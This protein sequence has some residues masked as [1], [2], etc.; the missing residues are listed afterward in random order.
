MRKRI[1]QD[2]NIEVWENGRFFALHKKKER[3][4]VEPK[5]HARSK[6]NPTGYFYF[7]K[8]INGK[9]YAKSCIGLMAEAFLKKPESTAHPYF[10]DKNTLNYA[11]KNIGWSSEPEFKAQLLESRR[12]KTGER[13]CELC[14]N[15]YPYSSESI[16]YPCRIKLEGRVRTA[17]RKRE[18]AYYAKKALELGGFTEKQEE[19]LRLI[20]LGMSYTDIAKEENVS[21]QAIEAFAKK[22]FQMLDEGIYTKKHQTRKSNPNKLTEEQVLDIFHSNESMTELAKRYD[23]NYKTIQRIKYGE[24][25][26]WLTG[27]TTGKRK[28]NLKKE[29]VLHIFHSKDNA[30]DLANKYNVHPVTIGNIRKGKTWRNITLEG[31]ENG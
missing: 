30:I 24:N 2:G 8:S 18:V 29:E 17:E 4:E 9:N 14:S 10:K 16:C 13:S 26:S 1:I 3:E 25:W 5:I 7:I 31:K 11:L 27:E 19:R 6:K 21:K 28:R 12:R 23:V 20:Q 22:T 15:I